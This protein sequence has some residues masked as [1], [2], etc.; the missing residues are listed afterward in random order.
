MLELKLI[1]L[2]RKLFRDAG[3]E[4]VQLT[5]E[6]TVDVNVKNECAKLITAFIGFSGSIFIKVMLQ[7]YHDF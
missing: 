7:Y 5:Y 4:L 1:L 3:V 6:I 2:L